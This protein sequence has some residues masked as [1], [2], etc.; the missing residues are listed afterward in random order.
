MVNLS[1]TNYASSEPT[2]YLGY[3]PPDVH[4]A[5]TFGQDRYRYRRPGEYFKRGRPPLLATSTMT[6]SLFQRPST[7]NVFSITIYR[8][9]PRRRPGNF[10][11]GAVFCTQGKA[12]VSITH[13]V[14]GPLREH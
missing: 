3:R 5:S 2:W 7:R 12:S 6:W 9:A 11:R 14:W 4:G 10:V 13:R 1:G 8:L